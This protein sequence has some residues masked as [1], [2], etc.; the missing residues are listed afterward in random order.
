LTERHPAMAK[1]FFH[2]ANEVITPRYQIPTVNLND[3]IANENNRSAEQRER[4]ATVLLAAAGERDPY[5]LHNDYGQDNSYDYNNT[6]IL[7]YENITTEKLTHL[8]E[9]VNNY[10]REEGS[11][12]DL[13]E[14]IA[15]AIKAGYIRPQD[16]LDPFGH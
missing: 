4:A 7:A 16:T 13:N 8:I 5:D 14:A 12:D 9:G 3:V 11:L 15:R 2:L 10:C 6:N 1:L